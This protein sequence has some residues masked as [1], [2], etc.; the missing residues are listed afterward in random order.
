[1]A[2]ARQLA[3]EAYD[4]YWRKMNGTA[5]SGAP[6]PRWH[7][8]SSKTEGEAW[9][10][11]ILYVIEDVE[12]ELADYAGEGDAPE[13]EPSQEEPAPAGSAGPGSDDSETGSLVA[14]LRSAA[15]R[16]R[17]A[18]FRL[19]GRGDYRKAQGE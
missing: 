17:A 2:M 14:I 12:F 10:E 13:P 19:P 7:E 15:G 8:I 3:A 1:M 11:A 18:A 5:A 16:L 6:L 9:L 4:V